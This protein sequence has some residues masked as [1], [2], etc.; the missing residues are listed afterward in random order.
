MLDLVGAWQLKAAYFVGQES[1]ERVDFL[2]AEPFGYTVFEG[3][4]R[5]V[6]L[7]TSRRRT[8]AASTAD[9]AGLFKSMAAYTGKWRID[10]ETIVTKVDG[11][12]DP[13]WVGTEQ[14]RYY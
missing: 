1:A 2:G 12:W 4:G 14:V 6:S 3:Y 7:L 11:A 13:G 8:P 10:S 5:M 9:M